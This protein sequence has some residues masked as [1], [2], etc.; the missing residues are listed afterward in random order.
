[1]ELFDFFSRANAEYIEQLYQQYRNDPASVDERWAV[2]FA[3]FEAGNSG[4]SI[5][6][7]LLSSK[8]GSPA[9]GVNHL[10]HSY[11]EL[12]HFIAKLNPLGN[13]REDFPLL[14]LSEFGFSE[15]DDLSRPVGNGGFAGES[16]QTL[17]DLISRLKETYCGSLGVEYMDISDKTQREWLQQ[18]M[19]PSFNRPSL[20]AEE[21]TYLYSKLVAAEG[22]EQFLHTKY[23]GQKRFSIQGAESII[24]LLDTLLTEAGSNGVEEILMGMAH[25][26]RLNVLTHIL[27][28]PYELVLRE[29]EGTAQP[30]SD[31]GDGDVKYH[32]G[33]TNTRTTASGG[34]LLVT[35]ASN[36]SHLE[37][38]DPVVVGMAKAKQ[39]ARNDSD[40]ARVVPILLHG[41][42]A[43]T[44]QGVVPETLS[45]SE[46]SGYR[47]GGT[48]HIIV[49]NQVGFTATANET[50][51]TPYPT[52]VAKMIQA[53]VFH[54]NG[55]D[56]EAVVHAARLAM[57]FRQAF[58][59]DV[60]IDVWC[61]RRFGHNETDDPTFTQPVMYQ[62]IDALPS[63]RE[64]YA[65]K[66]KT[67]GVL[68]DEQI[69]RFQTELREQLDQGQGA[70][71][72]VRTRPPVTTFRD[73]W[74]GFDR[75][76]GD[77]TARTAISQQ[78]ILHVTSIGTSVPEGFNVHR[79]LV[80]LLETRRLMAKGDKTADWGCAEMWALG[81]LL[82]EGTPVRLMGQD[83][84]RGTFSHRH[85]VLHDTM[86]GDTFTPLSQFN[87]R[88]T[89]KNSML[90][91]FAVMGFEYGY[92]IADPRNLVMWEAQFGDFVNGAQTV[93][94]Q[95]LVSGESK[96]D[97]M[98]GLVLLLP[99]GY[100]GQGPEH[101]SAR[102]E[103][104]LQSCAEN[105]IQVCYPSMP[106]QYFH[107]LRRQMHRRFRKPLVLMMPKSLLRDE[108]STSPVADFTDGALHLVLDDTKVDPKKVKRVLFCTGKVYFGLDAARD[109]R[110]QQDTAIVRVE[111]L[112]P[113][114]K[115][116][117][118]S[119][120]ARY[121]RAEEFFWVQEEP[122]NMGA[123]TFIEPRL[124]TCLPPSR[125][126]HYRGRGEAAS[127]AHGFYRVHQ[128]EEQEFIKSAL[129]PI[130]TD[131]AAL[132]ESTSEPALKE[133]HGN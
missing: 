86:T 36:P 128:L 73:L 84:E 110:K 69:E 15:T 12:G 29:F 112:Y 96:W 5:L 76:R 71:R 102:L 13:N 4:N 30:A 91:E 19:E 33:Y 18:K 111:Q 107:L 87:A 80:K 130:S 47:T 129:D 78:D 64:L 94:D 26:G 101:S 131:T 60:F 24:P 23:V 81:S 34:S 83:S 105:N 65:E 59:V 20:S 6:E 93:L 62:K 120:L 51:F 97:R 21:K 109:E 74:E 40:G 118:E 117:I 133:R 16:G 1:M 53:P 85:A 103:R 99:H 77:W 54:V 72:E 89:I 67:E 68:T 44:G 122:K 106:S 41:E 17:G 2:F 55:D 27:G 123:W 32:M 124:R 35:L 39:Q 28:K 127:P 66:L 43:F 100:E 114:P 79:K 3:G 8:S 56:P 63:V 70:A 75:A 49:N 38:V 11:R 113:F 125:Q 132:G 52:D 108:R 14:R 31:E 42:A 61:Y 115:T 46:L 7:K 25:R 45:L 22:F 95:F 37:V 82:H 104:F 126:L 92:S 119:A 57:Q 88:F 58:K 98:S 121:T 116:E 10:V 90:S 48:I 50:R 9:E